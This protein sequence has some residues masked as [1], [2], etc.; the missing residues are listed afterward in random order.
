LKLPDK[1]PQDN[2]PSEWRINELSSI[3]RD[4]ENFL[5]DPNDWNVSLGTSLSKEIDIEMT[6][7]HW[8]VVHFIRDWY[9]I[10]QAVPEARKLL[11]SMKLEYGAEKAIRRYLYQ[12]YPYGYGQQACKIAGMRKPL[13]W[14]L[15]I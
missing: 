10:N 6:N 7:E 5:L 14:M 13:K 2:N 9:E 11:K 4:N 12:L 8:F 1:L 15:D 3:E